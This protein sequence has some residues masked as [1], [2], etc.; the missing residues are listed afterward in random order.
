MN[1]QWEY[2]QEMIGMT[3]AETQLGTLGSDGWELAGLWPKCDTVAVAFFKR[4]VH[5][6]DQSTLSQ[7]TDAEASWIEWKQKFMESLRCLTLSPRTRN[8]VQRGLPYPAD[9]SALPLSRQMA[10]IRREPSLIFRVEQVRQAPLMTFDQWIRAVMPSHQLQ[11][12][13]MVEF[14]DFK[15]ARLAELIKAGHEYLDRVQ[16]ATASGKS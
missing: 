11:H 14:L 7:P 8:I 16:R 12:L 3:E 15:G 6:E 10:I 1:D 4:R 13:L 5:E 9:T 2:R